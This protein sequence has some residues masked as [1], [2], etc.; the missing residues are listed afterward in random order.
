MGRKLMF[1]KLVRQGP[2]YLK[3]FSFVATIFFNEIWIIPL[4]RILQ[5]HRIVIADFLYAPLS[6]CDLDFNIFFSVKWYMKCFIYWTVD[7]KSSKLQY[8]LRS[9]EC[10]LNNCVKKPEKVR[11]STGF[12]PVTSWYW[13][14]ALTNWAMNPLTC[15]RLILLTVLKHLSECQTSNET[16]VVHCRVTVE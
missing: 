12:E 9:Y 11:T 3:Q 2:Y 6:C 4:L 14:D 8:D 7:L 5:M 16:V 13:C 15:W 10:N 1:L